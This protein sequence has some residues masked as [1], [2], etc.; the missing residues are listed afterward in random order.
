MDGVIKIWDTTT[1]RLEIDQQSNTYQCRAIAF[2]PDGTRI[3][4]AGF[5]GTLRLLDAATGREMLTIFAHPSLVAD[6]AFSH[7]G[8]QLASASY[9]HTV[10][11]WDATP[12]DGDPQAAHCVTLTGHKQL[13]S[14][15]AFSPDGRWLASASWD[16]TVKLWEAS[17]SG[18]P[19]EFI[20]RYTLRGHSGNVSGVAFSSDKRTVASGSWDK[21]VK[22][23]DLQA[24]VGDSLTEL[25]TIPCAERVTGLALSP[26]GRLLAIGQTNGIAL[27]DPATGTQ[28]HSFKPTPAPVPAVAF[29]PDSRHLVSAGASDPAIKVW[30]LAGEKPPFEIRHYSNPNSS[31]AV[32]PDGR[33]IAAPGRDQAADEPTVKVWDAQT[34]ETLRTLKGHK[35]YVWKVAFSPDGRYLSSGS[36]DSTIKV[37]DLTAPKSAEP[38]T[39]RGHAGFIY[40]LAFSPD[41]RRLASASGSTHHGEVKVWDASLWENKASVGR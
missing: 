9:D 3:A 25:R 2:S 22:L 21:T 36:W 39:L 34:H 32:S 14:G 29:S 19:G 1:G 33:L 41:G 27:Y 38:V 20:P 37:W 8:N 6:A 17:A 15:V 30:D 7:D 23:W 40:G 13:V 28:A 10:R 11:I 26:D 5:D 35:G 18:T 12:L 16:G 24:P 31:V 4:L